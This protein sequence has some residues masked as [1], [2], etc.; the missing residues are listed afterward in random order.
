MAANGQAE[1]DGSVFGDWI[2]CHRR[3]LTDPGISGG[4]VTVFAL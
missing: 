2:D 1:S 4:Q 3:L